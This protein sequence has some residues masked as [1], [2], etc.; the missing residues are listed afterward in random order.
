MSPE[1]VRR[2]RIAV[3]HRTDI[4]SLGVTLYEA[5]AGR[6][7]FRGRDHS[8]LLTQIITR[9]PVA[10]WQVDSARSGFGVERQ[11]S[12]WSSMPSPSSSGSQPSSMPSPSESA[13]SWPMQEPCRTITGE[14]K[15]TVR[16]SV[17]LRGILTT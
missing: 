3:D 15:V 11:L 8:D 1:Q 16:P 13:G 5:L 4:Y 9:D 2:R 17:D 6:P 7:P 10:P 12:R 14:S